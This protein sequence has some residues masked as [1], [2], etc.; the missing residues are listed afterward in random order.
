MI[1]IIY[2]ISRSEIVVWMIGWWKLIIDDWGGDNRTYRRA[3]AVI[4]AWEATHFSSLKLQ[5]SNPLQLSDRT[6]IEQDSSWSHLGSA[7][8]KLHL[9]IL[10][11]IEKIIG[12]QISNE[13]ISDDLIC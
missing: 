1:M 10:N 13:I 8:I 4:A 9:G 5:L 11:K 2:E 6:K 7:V 12:I 3:A